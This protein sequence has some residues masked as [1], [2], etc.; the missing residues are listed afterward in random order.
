MD[1]KLLMTYHD[2]R[3]FFG[4]AGRDE[5]SNEIVIKVVNAYDKPYDVMID[6]KG[7]SS[8]EPKGK[9]ITLSANSPEDENSL[10][11]PMKYIP[12]EEVYSEFSPSFSYTF[13]PYSITILR[14]K[15]KR[16]M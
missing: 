13:K 15:R 4:L 6:L 12:K 5:K 10:N 3:K 14:I 8:V 11:E 16:E 7:I 1:G 9:I 2:P